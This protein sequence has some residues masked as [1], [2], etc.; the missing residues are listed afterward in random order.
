[1]KLKVGVFFG[2]ESVEHEISN[3]HMFLRSDKV[4]LKK[5]TKL[6]LKGASS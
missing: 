5:D 3:K 2:G 1:M 4:Y 6:R